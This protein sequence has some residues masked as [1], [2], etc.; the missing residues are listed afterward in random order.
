MARAPLGNLGLSQFILGR[1][2]RTQLTTPCS[3]HILSRVTIN[4]LHLLQDTGMRAAG[5]ALW[6]ARERDTSPI[7]CIFTLFQLPKACTV[8]I[9]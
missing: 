4:F 7:P 8:G 5:E 3:K 2:S 9:K 6:C 1:F